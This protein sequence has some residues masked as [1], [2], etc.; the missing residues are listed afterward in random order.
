MSKTQPVVLAG[1]DGTR[2]GRLA[3]G[4]AAERAASLGAHLV[5]VHVT[6]ALPLLCSITASPEL[7]AMA[8]QLRLDLEADAF[9]DT[10]VAA[11]R[12]GVDWSFVLAAEGDVAKS[13]RR[14]A[15]DR[16]AAL[17]VVAARAEHRGFHRCPARRLAQACDRP[18][19]VA[20]AT[21]YGML[22]E[23]W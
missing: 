2:S 23:A 5:G 1:V 19:V 14:E 15:K 22:E 10:A 8:P 20:D 18:V 4:V 12:A 17:V 6:P 9:L 13:L 7:L 21:V 11:E 16:D 3:L